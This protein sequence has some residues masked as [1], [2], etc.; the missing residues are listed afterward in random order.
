VDVQARFREVIRRHRQHNR[1][2]LP[3]ALAPTINEH[4]RACARDFVFILLTDGYASRDDLDA[5]FED[6]ERLKA[7]G[8]IIAQAGCMMQ[9]WKTANSVSKLSPRDLAGLQCPVA[10]QRIRA[11]IEDAKHRN[12]K[13]GRDILKPYQPYQTESAIRRHW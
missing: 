2:A 5:G 13:P 10:E 11:A 3:V 6:V 1:L 8:A 12:P 4:L 9:G 7:H